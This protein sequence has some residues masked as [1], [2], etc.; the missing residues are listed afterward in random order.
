MYE[1]VTKYV[2]E[3]ILNYSKY[4]LLKYK[5]NNIFLAAQY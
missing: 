1:N 4:T 5:V 3:Q 2:I